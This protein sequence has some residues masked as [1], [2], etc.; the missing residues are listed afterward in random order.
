MR[1]V[2]EDVQNDHDL[3][4]DDPRGRASPRGPDAISCAPLTSRCRTRSLHGCS[5]NDLSFH[6]PMCPHG[7]AS[8]T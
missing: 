1:T 6:P 5:Q 3:S 4:A 8:M 2:R 7:M